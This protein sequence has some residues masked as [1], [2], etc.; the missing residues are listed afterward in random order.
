M[1]QKVTVVL[2]DDIDGGEAVESFTFGFGGADYVID[3]NETNAAEFTAIMKKYVGAGRL[4][5]SG[6]RPAR[7]AGPDLKA[8]R[9][10]AAENNVPVPDRGRIKKSVLDQYLAAQA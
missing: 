1:A 5:G 7:K 4:V 2:E 3:L 6:R 8:V 10:W 9:A